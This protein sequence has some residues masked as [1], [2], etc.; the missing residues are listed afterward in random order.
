MKLYRITAAMDDGLA[1]DQAM[2]SIR[3]PIFFSEKRIVENH[4]R[5]WSSSR[6]RKAIDRLADAEKQSRRGVSADTSAAQAMIAL[7]LSVRR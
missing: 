6:C 4:L 2:S 7:A 5:F 3:P 1:R